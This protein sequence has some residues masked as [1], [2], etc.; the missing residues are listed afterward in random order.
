MKKTPTE[1]RLSLAFIDGTMFC[2]IGLIVF[3][4]GCGSME[5]ASRWSEQKPVLD[6]NTAEWADKSITIENKKLTLGLMNDST[7]VYL[8]L[9]TNDRQYSRMLMARGL[10]V[11]FDASGGRE[12]TFGVH[13]PL[14]ITAGRPQR[15]SDISRDAETFD[16]QLQ[17]NAPLTDLE[18]LGPGKEDRHKMPIMATGG[19]QAKAIFAAG[20]FVYELKVPFPDDSRF[21]FSIRSKAGTK[22]GVGLETP[23]F[24]S[25]GGEQGGF[26]GGGGGGR[27]G[28]GGGRGGRGGGGGGSMGSNP[29][30]VSGAASPLKVWLSVQLASPDSATSKSN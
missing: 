19:I 26:G 17:A 20:S 15:S 29:E 30:R 5:L 21:P 6:G 9:A 3:L 8:M 1:H 22:I 23:D 24:E 14:G 10:T 12:K 16:S 25:Q 2:A 4:A 27:G 18:I 28:G 11:W 7:F 13:Y